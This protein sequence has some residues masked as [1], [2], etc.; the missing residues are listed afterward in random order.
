[1]CPLPLQRSEQAPSELLRSP[2]PQGPCGCRSRS[3][4]PLCWSQW[5][6]EVFRR[7]DSDTLIGIA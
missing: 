5:A 1:M 3:G 6:Q 4:E 7:S 2:R